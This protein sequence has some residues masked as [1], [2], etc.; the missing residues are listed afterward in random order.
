LHGPTPEQKMFRGRT[1]AML[2]R[3]GTVPLPVLVLSPVASTLSNLP[4]SNYSTSLSS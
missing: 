2:F 3:P 1:E 4:T